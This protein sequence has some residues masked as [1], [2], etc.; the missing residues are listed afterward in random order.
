MS[1]LLVPLRTKRKKRRRKKLEEMFDNVI[2][3]LVANS[4]IDVMHGLEK[5]FVV[6][7]CGRFRC[8]T[9]AVFDSE[10]KSFWVARQEWC[11]V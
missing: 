6:L 7:F 1:E 11:G 4:N 10:T 3:Q 5:R 9:A 8:K 2:P